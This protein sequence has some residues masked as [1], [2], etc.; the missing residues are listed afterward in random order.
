MVIRVFR[1]GKLCPIKHW[2]AGKAASLSDEQQR[3]E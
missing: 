1:S 2:R 3:G